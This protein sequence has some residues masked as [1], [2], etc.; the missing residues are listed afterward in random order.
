M[1]IVERCWL[2]PGHCAASLKHEDPKGFI[3]TGLVPP[4]VDPRIY[5][6]VSWVEEHARKLGFVDRSDLDSAE[7]RIVELEEELRI[8]DEFAEAAEYT[9]THLGGNIRKK[10]GR[11]PVNTG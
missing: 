9:V 1:D 6:S 8:A 7:R 3:D 5:I 2:A 10:P 11:K 4:L